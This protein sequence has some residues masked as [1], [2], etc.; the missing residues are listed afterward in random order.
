MHNYP[1]N[2]PDVLLCVRFLPPGS[3][4]KWR[5]RRASDAEFGKMDSNGD[6]KASFEEFAAWWNEAP[7]RER[8]QRQFR[9]DPGG[10]NRTQRNTS[11]AFLG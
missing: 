5:W 3:S 4:A 9:L 1:R 11:G 7:A 8:L 10:K 2:A 6:G